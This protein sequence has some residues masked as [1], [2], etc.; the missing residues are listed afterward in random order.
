[1]VDF[2]LVLVVLVPVLLFVPEF[3]LGRV[4]GYDDVPG[5]RLVVVFASVAASRLQHRRIL[6]SPSRRVTLLFP[7]L[8][9][10]FGIHPSGFFFTGVTKLRTVIQTAQDADQA[11]HS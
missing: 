7:A 10:R 2:V 3:V 5:S 8:P 11:S 4:V 9:A 6:L 1:V